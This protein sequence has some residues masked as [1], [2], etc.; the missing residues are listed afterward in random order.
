MQAIGEHGWRFSEAETSALALEALLQDNG[1]R[2]ASGSFLEEHI[3]R[4]LHLTT[5]GV[6]GQLEDDVRPYFRSLLGVH[7]IARLVLAVRDHPAF[8]ALLGHLRLLNEGNALQVTKSPGRDSATNKLFELVVATLAMQCGTVVDLDD[9]TASEGNNPDVLVTVSGRRWGIACKVLHSTHPEGFLDHL[10]KG[11]DQIEKSPA[12]IGVV[13]FNLKN[14][15]DHDA[16]WPLAQ[17]SGSAD[18]GPA[19]WPNR[20]LAYAAL[21]WQMDE[22]GRRLR[23]QVEDFPSELAKIFNGK[24]S[25]PAFLLWG[26][27]A[28]GVLVDGRPAPTSA[29]RMVAVRAGAVDQMAAQFMECLYWAAFSDSPNRGPRPAV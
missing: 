6:Q 8:P 23:A 12:T 17:I 25:V 27:T 24:K 7:E 16:L 19:A 11:V 1:I 9:P 15:L 4:V 20:E 29:R 28:T 5:P 26:H 3:L 22:I 21:E 10:R 18:L 13:A 2:I 14:V